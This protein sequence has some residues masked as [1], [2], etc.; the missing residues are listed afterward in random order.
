MKKL[1]I[2]KLLVLMMMFSY[3]EGYQVNLQSVRQTGMGHT[4]VALR[5][6]VDGIHF[7]PASLVFMRN[8]VQFSAG[9]SGIL[10]NNKYRSGNLSWKSDNPTGTPAYFYAGFKVYDN[11]AIGLSFTTPY[12]NSLDWGKN[13]YGAHLVQDISLK[14][15]FFQ[16]TISYKVNDK[17]SIGG[18]LMILSG[19]LDLNKGLFERG[20]GVLQPTLNAAFG[21]TYNDVVPA[22]VNLS[23]D[24]K[25]AMGFNIG[26][27]YKINEQ[28]T[29]GASYRSK[30][31]AKVKDGKAKTSFASEQLKAALSSQ[32]PPLEQG[33]FAATLPMPANATIGVSYKA[34]DRLTIA[35]EIQAVQWDAYKELK[36]DFSPSALDPADL[37]SP[38]KWDNTMIYRIGAEYKM[39]ERLDLRAGIYYDETPIQK[40]LYNPETPGMDK[41]GLSIGASF[42][43]VKN[44]T[45]DFAML[46][47]H[48]F[49]I[50]AS[51]P[52]PNPVVPNRTFGGTYSSSAIIPS[53][54]L[55]Y[56]F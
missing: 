13:W 20:G 12:G 38:K 32:L 53:I 8:S 17:L 54:G 21:D 25:V 47:I 39:T 35:A 50:V 18:G 19:N 23:G 37:T 43:P 3:A 44:F 41:L 7:N 34:N 9:F 52:D 26:V 22:S 29:L 48:G 28:W 36:I 14:A 5:L 10:S 4:G 49:D 51:T 11:L 40:D 15:Y 45:V 31:K 1:I 56:S 16:P 24:A 33:S 30:V 27:Q 46:Y 55:T 2:S 6:G 42:S